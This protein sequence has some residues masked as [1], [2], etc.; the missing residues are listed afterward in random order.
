[1]TIPA[2]ANIMIRI[3]D[4]HL[5]PDFYPDPYKFNPDNFHPKAVSKRSKY[6]FIPFSTG[7]R[8][9]IGTYNLSVRTHDV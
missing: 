3:N 2:G 4:L 1:M 8:D 5:N 6:S 7:S 9:C